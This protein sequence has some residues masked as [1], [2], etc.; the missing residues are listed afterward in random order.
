VPPVQYHLV[1]TIEPDPGSITTIKEN[2]VFS[3]VILPQQTTPLI[4]NQED[5]YNA[6][7][8]NNAKFCVDVASLT[9]TDY[10]ITAFA[11]HD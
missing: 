3:P 8:A 7:L 5:R 2:E 1:T 6:T 4:Y 10:K 9:L 11:K